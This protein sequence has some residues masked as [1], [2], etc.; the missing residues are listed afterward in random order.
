[1]ILETELLQAPDGSVRLLQ[2]TDT[3]LF[4]SV[5]SQLLGVRTADSL[6]AVLARI[7]ANA[8]PYDLIL[9][10]GDLSQDHS[11]DSYQRF[12]DMLAPLGKPIYW[13]PGNH[14]DGP[15]MTQRLYESGISEAK[16]LV[17]EYWQI[18]LLDTQV[19]G[20]PHG[21]LADHQLAMLDHALRSHPDKHTLIAVH[22]QGV[23]VGCGW[24]DQHNLKN[25]DDLFAVL[26][27]YPSARAI[28][29][30]HVHQEF[31]EMHR[32]VRLIAT[33][34]TCIQFK[35]L[36]HDFTLDESGP[37]WRYLTLYPDGRI[38]TEVWRLP[39]GDFQPQADARGY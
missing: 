3:H 7:Q 25:A 27:R 24:L 39:P 18:V 4:G 5:D 2:I 15:L 6:A 33:P 31:D 32:G 38:A 37:G 22:H 36:C 19:R 16:W 26:A 28:L 12:A 30:G 23:P 20:K 17:G 14:D 13:L 21:L 11:D 10:T 1:V 29:F 35:P 34:S 9:A 8:H